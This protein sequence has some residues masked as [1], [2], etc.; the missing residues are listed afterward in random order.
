MT[1]N[2]HTSPIRLN[3]ITNTVPVTIKAHIISY[4]IVT[5]SRIIARA[6]RTF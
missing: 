3:V 1:F 6:N 4:M 5:V 2:S